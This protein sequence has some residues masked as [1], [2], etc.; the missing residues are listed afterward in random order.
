MPVMPSTPS[1]VVGETP[2]GSGC[3]A[4]SPSSAIT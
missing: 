2:S 4:R 3:I 1:A